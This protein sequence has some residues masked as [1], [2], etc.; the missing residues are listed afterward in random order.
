LRADRGLTGVDD[1]PCSDGEGS[2]NRMPRF[3]IRIAIALGVLSL[4]GAAGV[5][6]IAAPRL[7][8]L[9]GDTNTTRTYTGTAAT[10]FNEAAL[11]SADAGP[12]LLRNVPV[13]L[14]HTTKVLKTKGNNALVS[15]AGSVVAAGTTV[16]GYQYQYAVNRT[17][18]GPGTGFSNV[19]AQKGVT[20]NWPI[21][22]AK[23]DY[24]GWI[25]DTQTTA[26]LKYTGTAKRGGLSTNV[27]TLTAP[28]AAITDPQT[29]KSLPASLPKDTFVALSAGLNLPAGQLSGLQQVLAAEP[30]PV[31]LNYTY[32]VTATYWVE[33]TTGEIVDLQEHEVRTLVLTAGSTV[34]PITPILDVSYT[35]SPAQLKV[36]VSDARKDADQVNLLYRTA[37]VALLVV[38]VLLLA[39]AL[40][41]LWLRRRRTTPMAPVAVP[42]PETITRTPASVGGSGIAPEHS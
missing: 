20:F 35:S 19:T 11:T 16:A 38:G 10:L 17:S 25:S 34:V 15:D 5:Y 12:V 29:L 9:P 2:V 39:F 27:F 40:L 28:A 23:K 31:P 6:W 14:P 41:V 4:M 24:T 18:M 30:D 33:P 37:P 13:T 32:Q 21:R 26:P 8:V 42:Q 36:A 1:A 7:A 3:I 22:T